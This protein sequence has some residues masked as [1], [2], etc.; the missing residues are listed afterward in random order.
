[1]KWIFHEREAR[2][3][4]SLT[5]DQQPVIYLATNHLLTRLY[6]DY[7]TKETKKR[8]VYPSEVANFPPLHE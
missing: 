4:Y 1:M 3:T 2:V 8:Q 6:F 5:T 7:N